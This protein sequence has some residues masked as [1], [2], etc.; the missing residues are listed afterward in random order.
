M[1]RPERFE[2]PTFWFVANREESQSKNYLVCLASLTNSEQP[3]F[4]PLVVPNLVPNQLVSAGI[5]QGRA[6]GQSRLGCL[7]SQDWGETKKS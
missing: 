1:V 5:F 6:Y 4:P 2:L 7:G 3:F